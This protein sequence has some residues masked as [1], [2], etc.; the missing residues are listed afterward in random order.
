MKSLIIGLLSFISSSSF[1]GWL[2]VE[3]VAKPRASQ[4]TVG[5]E[6]K[7]YHYI[8]TRGVLEITNSKGDTCRIS[9]ATLKGVDPVQLGETLLEKKYAQVR[10]TYSQINTPEGPISAEEATTIAISNFKP[11]Q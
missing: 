5:G 4:N 10:C 6:V 11:L 1:A 3:Y 7:S 2:T 8:N 9:L